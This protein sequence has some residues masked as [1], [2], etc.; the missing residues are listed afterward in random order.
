MAIIDSDG[1]FNGERLAALSDRAR[2]FWPWFYSAANGYARL[3]LNLKAIRSRCFSAWSS[4]PTEADIELMLAEYIN[5]HLMFIY[6]V[7]GRQW[8]Q[9]DTPAKFLPRHLTKK[10]K[11]S[12]HPPP[13][14]REEFQKSY[15]ATKKR[16]SLS[17]H[18]HARNLFT[19]RE[20]VRGIGEGE[21][22]GVGEG[23]GEGEGVPLTPEPVVTYPEAQPR[24][25]APPPEPVGAPQSPRAVE[26]PLRPM[27]TPFAR[28]TPQAERPGELVVGDLDL[29]ELITEI[30]CAHPRSLLRSLRWNEVRQRDTHG[31]LDAVTAEASGQGVTEIE[32]ARALLAITKNFADKVPRHE[33]KFLKSVDEFYLLREYRRDP[34]EFTHTKTT[35][36]EG[37]DN[38]DITDEK[39]RQ[40]RAG[41]AEH[42]SGPQ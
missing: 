9:F 35:P 3:E 37:G 40:A 4:P 2:L 13:G 27:P 19:T 28:E 5:S 25:A 1:L 32:A 41:R 11:E 29:G 7:N 36:T 21:G 8:A 18:T 14:A 24:L 23:E 33:W 6:E 12:P 17:F 26:T 42:G 16:K 10:D 15:L 34:A 31:V 22:G 20:N 39:I 38:G 30:A